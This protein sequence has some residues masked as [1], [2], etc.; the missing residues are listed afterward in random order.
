MAHS[1]QPPL[2][3]RRLAFGG[4]VVCVGCCKSGGDGRVAGV[5]GPSAGGW[6]G[7]REVVA[8]LGG[9]L[10]AGLLLVRGVESSSGGSAAEDFGGLGVGFCVGGFVAFFGGGRADGRG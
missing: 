3:F 6:L 1:A 10:R 7:R 4:G 5:R 2:S 9:G 8:G